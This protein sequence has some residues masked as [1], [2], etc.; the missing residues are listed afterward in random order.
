MFEEFVFAEE[1]EKKKTK[2]GD[3]DFASYRD[4]QD[5]AECGK[6]SE[7]EFERISLYQKKTFLLTQRLE[8]E[9]DLP[10]KGEEV[11][12]MTTQ[13]LNSLSFIEF[14]LAKEKI[15]ETYLCVFSINY[16]TGKIIDDLASS[17]KL[18]NVTIL[19]S[20]LRNAAAASKYSVLQDFFKKN[21][22]IKVITAKSH[23]KLI[24]LRTE[25]DNYYLI[26]G[27]GNMTLNSRIELYYFHNSKE[28]FEFAK[29]TVNSVEDFTT[30]KRIEDN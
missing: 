22:K 14:V 19:L 6:E 11:I 26:G 30:K 24:A 5:E 15:V 23:T 21:E 4:L 9:I 10:K 12:I 2:K 1:P 13:P 25:S 8:G 3:E 7:T 18:G 28:F 27:S 20:N 29:K 17:G 16:K